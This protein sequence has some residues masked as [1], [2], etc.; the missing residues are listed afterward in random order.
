MINSASVVKPEDG[1]LPH[2]HRHKQ[3]T[4]Y[5]SDAEEPTMSRDGTSARCLDRDHNGVSM[6]MSRSAPRLRADVL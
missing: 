2:R 5:A 4:G 3:L 1:R 6:T